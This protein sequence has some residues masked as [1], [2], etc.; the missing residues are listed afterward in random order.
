MK[1]WKWF[2]VVAIAAAIFLAVFKG[3]K[4]KSGSNSPFVQVTRG[5]IER[6][7]VATGTIGP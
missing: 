3:L 4:G 1:S 6:H 7:A 2:L 5:D